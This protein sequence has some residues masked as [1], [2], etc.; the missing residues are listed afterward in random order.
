M[1]ERKIFTL[2]ELLAVIAIIAILASLL[3]PSLKK[4]RERAKITLCQSNLKQVH[5]LMNGYAGDHDG[6][7]SGS[8]FWN[9]PMSVWLSWFDPSTTSITDT[10]SRRNP[11]FSEEEWANTGQVFYCPSA[12]LTQ[13]WG[14]RD[15]R[16]WEGRTTYFVLNN[17]QRVYTPEQA[18]GGQI[19]KFNPKHT[20]AQDWIVKPVAGGIE[21]DIYANSHVGG[22][23]VMQVD[24]AVSFQ[25]DNAF[26]LG[27][28]STSGLGDNS[29]YVLKPTA[30]SW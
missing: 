3:L 27:K 2:I 13:I 30:C 10:R 8:T 25:P 21:Q 18:H 29:H 19:F 23:N 4:A 1:R 12:P 7:L 20:L 11:Y 28:T 26:S 17:I 15:D 9:E 16:V 24:G 14:K 22:G 5:V 6:Y